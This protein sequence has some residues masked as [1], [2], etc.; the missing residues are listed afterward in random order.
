MWHHAESIVFIFGGLVKY[1]ADVMSRAL[2]LVALYVSFGIF[3]APTVRHAFSGIDNEM[4]PVLFI[5]SLFLFFACAF[6]RTAGEDI[7]FGEQAWWQNPVSVLARIV[8]YAFSL[9]LLL[10]WVGV[11]TLSGFVMKVEGGLLLTL[12]VLIG[13]ALITRRTFHLFLILFRSLQLL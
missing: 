13:A 5:L 3:F 2:L 9:S 4:R 8:P 12:I 6:V 11:A 10:L 1:F 7:T